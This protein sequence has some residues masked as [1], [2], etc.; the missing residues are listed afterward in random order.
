MMPGLVSA[1]LALVLLAGAASAVP[2]PEAPR[3]P[4]PGITFDDRSRTLLV[5]TAP[6]YRLTLRKRDGA[7]VDLVDRR[8]GVPLLR[9]SDGCIWGAFQAGSTDYVG[10]CT[11]SPA[12]ASRFSYAW[13]RATTT[14]TLSYRDE[15]ARGVGAVVALTARDSSFDLR[16]TIENHAPA[17]LQNV[18]LPA[19]LR[20]DVDEVEAGYAPNYLPG[21]RLR[22]SFFERVGTGIVTY[23]SRLGFADY[24]ALDMRDGGHLALHS[25]AP[26]RPYPVD[27]GFLHGEP[28][29]ACWGPVFCVVHALQTWIRPGESWTSPAVRITVGS[30]VEDT[31]AAYRRDNGIDAYPSVA[32]KLG[33]RLP[34]LARAPLVK[35]DLPKLQPFGA[36][37]ADLRRLPVPSLLHPVSF[38]PGGHD[39]SD[40]DFL[41]PDPRWGST[42]DFRAMVV[43]AR[44]LGHLV[45]PYL[46]VSWWDERS[47]TLQALTPEAARG[48]AAHNERGEPI[49]ERY[50]HHSG[51]VTS[52]YSPLVRERIARLRDEWRDNVPVDCLFFDQLGARNSLYDFNPAAPHPLAYN[53]G[54]LEVMRPFREGCLMVEDGWDRL[55]RDASGFHGSALMMAREHDDPDVRYGEG[56][57]EPYPLATR[58]LHDKVLLYQHD[59]FEGT[60]TTDLEV[61]SWNMAFGL[62]SSYSWDGWADSLASP[63]LDVAGSFQRAVGPHYAGVPLARYRD[64]AEGLTESTFGDL[65]VT[66]SW[67]P[68]RRARVGEHG[69]APQGFVA[70]MTDGRLLAGAFADA[71]A[72][73]P[74]SAGTHYLIVE[75]AETE[76]TV[77]QPLGADT[78]LVVDPPLSWQ[79]G[80]PLRATAIGRD[81]EVLG[82]AA[83]ELRER[84]FRFDYAGTRNG[85]PVAAYRIT[86]G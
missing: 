10:G 11:F 40:P 57:W 12:S 37:G 15:D 25:V 43:D 54:W 61:L 21:V 36:W 1:L 66:A 34:P 29:G 35:A 86:V 45:M 3:L 48:V 5:V 42:A 8:A 78:A 28:P 7:I 18:L 14:L 24:L 41:P 85:R 82:E 79:A 32:E 73:E 83:G 27:L 4:G 20:A 6:G 68:A 49:V 65:V 58:L 77:R 60:M 67:D 72:G 81:G 33:A 80:Q 31:I 9:G 38:Q 17:V 76:V 56:N 70:V 71:F 44:A 22:P 16:A 51:P 47:P 59:L 30:P 63:W 50:N 52:P 75:R 13:D 46:N 69:L 2:I 23:P 84:R 74:L 62:I 19:A 53:D 64:L 39:G 26:D 55:A